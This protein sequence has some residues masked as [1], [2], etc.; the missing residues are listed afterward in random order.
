MI[1]Q[2]LIFI[3]LLFATTGVSATD[4]ILSL[5]KQGDID[6]ARQQIA[7]HSTASRRDGNLLFLDL[8]YAVLLHLSLYKAF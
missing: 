1:F 4:K 2:R 3:V 7:E 6:R 5:I 8:K